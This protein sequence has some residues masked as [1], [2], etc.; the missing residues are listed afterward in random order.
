L[1]YKKGCTGVNIE[2][3]ISLFRI[4][5]KERSK[6]TNIN[7]GIGLTDKTELAHFY[8]MSSSTLNTF[9]KEEA[10]RINN[11]NDH[12]IKEVRRKK[13]VLRIYSSNDV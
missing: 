10:E 1:F 5:K 11:L 8:I 6:D 7:K 4:L 9:S 13:F 3:D 12:Y 2:P